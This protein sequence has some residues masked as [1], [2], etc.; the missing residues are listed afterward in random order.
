MEVRSTYKYARI[1]PFKVREVTRE[2]QGLPVSAA[3]DVLAFTPKKAAFLIGKTLK[4]A[5]ANAENNANLKP[6]GLVVKE[7]T[8][9]EG[10]TLKRI[11]A[12]A[13]GSASRIL[14]RTSHIRIVL[15][16]EIAIETREARKAKRQA[17]K[18]AINRQT[19]STAIE[20]ATTAPDQKSAKPKRTS[21]TKKESP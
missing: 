7:A 14:K 8:V 5:I 11:M 12:R 21:K 17:E 1:S 15:S 13:R 20:G 3:L 2:I 9:G 16:D 19:A 18:K 6:D 10:P 4:S